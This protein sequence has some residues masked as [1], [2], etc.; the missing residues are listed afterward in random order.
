MLI[1]QEFFIIKIFL[2]GLFKKSFIEFVALLILLYTLG[3]WPQVMY[4]LSY[5]TRDWTHTPVSEGEVLAA[6]LPKNSLKITF[7]VCFPYAYVKVHVNAC[8]YVC[9]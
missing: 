8:V 1:S 7:R 9:V 2:Y 4:D 5:L 6:R 3:F